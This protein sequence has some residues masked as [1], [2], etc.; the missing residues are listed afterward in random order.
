MILWISARGS[1]FL[2]VM[3]QE[4]PLEDRP[5]FAPSSLSVVMHI[6]DRPICL[7][8]G[9][10][11]TGASVASPLTKPHTVCASITT[12]KTSFANL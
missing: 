3:A 11:S 5:C 9:T 8:Y 2:C 10:R 12:S 6:T 7:T 1:E 4:K